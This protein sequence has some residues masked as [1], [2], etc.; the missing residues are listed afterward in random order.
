MTTLIISYFSSVDKD[1]LG[2]PLGSEVLDTTAGSAASGPVATS[3][4]IAQVYSETAHYVT[5]GDGEPTASTD[6]AF[7]LPA[8]ERVLMRTFVAQGQTKKIAAV[9][10]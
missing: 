8:G 1:C 2:I 10:A 4:P 6:N 9:P 5:F 3:A 7:Y